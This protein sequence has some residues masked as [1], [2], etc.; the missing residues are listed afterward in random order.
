MNVQ[1]LFASYERT[2]RSVIRPGETHFGFLDRTA[3][4]PFPRLRQ[5]LDRWFSDLPDEQQA[6][7][8]T[9]LIGK[10]ERQSLAAFWELYLHACMRAAGYGIDFHPH[11]PEGK[12]HPDFLVDAGSTS[13]YLEA[14]IV[15]S[16]D[17]ERGNAR[18]EAKVQ[19][20]IDSQIRSPNFLLGLSAEIPSSEPSIPRLKASI[21]GWLNELNPDQV[22]AAFDQAGWG[23]LPRREWKEGSWT[24]ELTA[25]P[26]RPEQRGHPSDSSIG[27]IS[28]GAGW[29]NDVGR[30]RVAVAKKAK[31]YGKLDRPLVIAVL[32]DV[33]GMDGDTIDQA[34]FG[35]HQVAV[36]LRGQEVVMRPSR[37]HQ[38]LWRSAS[39]QVNRGVAGLLIGIR[40][41]PFRNP[42]TILER[43][44][45]LWHNPWTTMPV[46]PLCW[47]T[48]RFGKDT[49]DVI[50]EPGV[51][52]TE[53]FGVPAG[54]LDEP[55]P[56][57]WIR[58]LEKQIAQH[59][60]KV[61]DFRANPTVRPGM[62]KL[63]KEVIEKQQQER[64]RHL[65]K[66]IETF[67]KNIEK[68]KTGELK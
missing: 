4:E 23:A 60:K 2:D 5:L 40:I 13:F 61:D 1:R 44:P 47:P 29:L 64:I 68:Y 41:N 54:W 27:F 45:R 6:E 49:G 11:T 32:C 31:H 3:I 12:G 26:K 50:D 24:I 17:A 37:G 62:E 59:E 53:L 46:G 43:A 19:A 52:P 16:S 8:R 30:F 58:S 21:E 33:L 56:P 22:Q 15:G 14:T 55:Y 63:P 25:Y 66:E 9:R 48:R 28:S 51:P 42:A 35:R 36:S 57:A 39:G 38:A 7:M 67:K 65:E 34:L 20:A 18:R 10:D